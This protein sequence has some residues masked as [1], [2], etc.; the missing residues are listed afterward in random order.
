M[1]NLGISQ[2]AFILPHWGWG[3]G[4]GLAGKA[5]EAASLTPPAVSGSSGWWGSGAL[6]SEDARSIGQQGHQV[7]AE[8]GP[9]G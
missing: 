6:G 2:V 7:S 5:M 1:V 9:F 3:G 4:G 8:K